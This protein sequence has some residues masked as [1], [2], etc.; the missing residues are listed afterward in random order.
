MFSLY[1][2]ALQLLADRAKRSDGLLGRLLRMHDVL[3]LS[4]ISSKDIIRNMAL[5]QLTVYIYC[6]YY[7][8]L[9]SSPI[10]ALL[11][12]RFSGHSLFLV[13]HS[14]CTCMTLHNHVIFAR[15][16]VNIGIIMNYYSNKDH[17]RK[18]S[19]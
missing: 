19:T 6:I 1:I 7:I 11:P 15:Y 4:F 5:R 9:F 17:I 16:E 13:W 18:K 8:L 14:Y 3:Y 12:S 2:N 10:F